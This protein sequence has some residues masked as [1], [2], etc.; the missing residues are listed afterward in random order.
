[1]T[2]DLAKE[3]A[4][5]LGEV[6]VRPATR[7]VASAGRREIIEPRVKQVLVNGNKLCA[8]CLG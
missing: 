6:E 7:E 4:F 5:K 3:A 1:M 2:V 8:Y